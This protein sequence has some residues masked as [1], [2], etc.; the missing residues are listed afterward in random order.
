MDT[1]IIKEAKAYLKKRVELFSES[2]QLFLALLKSL[3]SDDIKLE[4]IARQAVKRD[5]TNL[6]LYKLYNEIWDILIK[7]TGRPDSSD[8][9]WFDA[10]Q[11][12]FKVSNEHRKSKSE[13]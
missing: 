5:G 7:L 13:K 8:K 11:T 2:L 10:L 4:F 3:S 1:L 9:L 12:L 6:S